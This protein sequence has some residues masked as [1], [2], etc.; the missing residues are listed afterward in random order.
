M[1]DTKGDAKPDQAS[2]QSYLTADEKRRLRRLLLI[3]ATAMTSLI[4]ILLTWTALRHPSDSMMTRRFENNGSAL[5]NHCPPAFASEQAE[6]RWLRALR[7]YPP[8]QL[9]NC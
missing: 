4:A 3:V 1:T 9:N 5:I 8:T 7:I 6:R 2:P